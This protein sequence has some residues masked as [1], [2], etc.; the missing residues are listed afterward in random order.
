MPACYTVLS[1]GA[2]N[3]EHFVAE[4][5]ALI[6]PQVADNFKKASGDERCIQIRQV[7]GTTHH[8]GWEENWKDLIRLAV[9][10][11]E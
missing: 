2:A 3:R 7:A 6:P 10:C 11:K 5:D 4:H 1:E 9:F 8:D